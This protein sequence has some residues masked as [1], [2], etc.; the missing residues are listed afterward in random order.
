VDWLIIYPPMKRQQKYEVIDSTRCMQQIFA[1]ALLSIRNAVRSKIILCL[2]VMLMVVIMV[3]PFSIR[4]DGTV[5][6]LIQI[7]L[8][9]T[10]GLAGIIMAVTSLWAGSSSV[11]TEID[12]KTIQMV[13]TKPV[14]KLQLWT[15]K[16]LGLNVI[17]LILLTLCGVT[18]YAMLHWHLHPDR[19]ENSDQLRDVARFLSSRTMVIPQQP[20]FDQ[21]VQRQLER[22]ISKDEIPAGMSDAEVIR[23]L[24]QQLLMEHN[25]VNPDGIKTWN[26]GRLQLP[27]S[28]TEVIL[29]FQFSSSVVGQNIVDGHWTIGTPD[30][31][32][33]IT[34]K[35]N[36]VSRVLG[37]LSFIMDERWQNA[38]LLVAYSG[39]N[40][41]NISVIFE[42][43]KMALLV[44]HGSFIGNFI[45][46][47]LIIFG[48]LAFLAAIGVTAGC[49]FSLPVASFVS[50]FVLIL[51]QAGSYIEGVAETKIDWPWS[52]VASENIMSW[53]TI[54]ITIVFKVLA[55]LMGP[56]INENVLGHISTGRTIG[57]S[58]MLNVLVI[59]GI[60][61]SIILGM[62]ASR[63]L[64]RRELALPMT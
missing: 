41:K 33:I 1:I 48:Q 18:T 43:D 20:V 23:R 5:A 25:T 22:M 11:S 57:I 30:D 13:A 8:S 4:G 59:Q 61:Y 29:Q 9:Y 16:W 50:F 36:H 12:D 21:D 15:G 3:L 2:I 39:Q 42:A 28:E 27:R 38:D 53:G 45:R 32:E 37:E 26:F 58:W 19:L 40:Q 60:I 44:P 10:L 64:S 35:E 34:I 7:M 31:P 49:L 52:A 47:L 14:T 56:L 55:F 17:N 62:I 24:Q 54:L 63:I 6:G 46:A 51:I